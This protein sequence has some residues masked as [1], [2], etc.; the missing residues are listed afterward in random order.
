MNK[1]LPFLL[2][3]DESGK[4]YSHPYLKAAVQSGAEFKVCGLDEYINAPLGTNF[5]YLPNIY[6]VGYDPL[7]G[8]FETLEHYKGKKVFAVSSFFPPAYLR[9]NNTAGVYNAGSCI[10][11][12]WA[13]TA[14]GYY[15][16]NFKISAMRIDKRRRQSPNFYDDDKVRSGVSLFYERNSR[17]RLYEHLANC[18]LNY[19]C[20]AAKNMFLNRWE[21]PVPTA[22]RCNARCIGCI[23]KN[24]K[25][26][27][28]APHGRIS[29]RPTVCE[30]AELMEH[31]LAT[32][33]QAIVSFGQGCEGE[34]LLET[35]NIAAAISTVRKGVLRGTINMNTNGSLPEKVS[36]LCD[37]GMDSFRISLN[38]TRENI[39]KLYFRPYSYKFKDVIRSI[40]TAKHKNKFVSINLFVF[41]GVIDSEAEVKS[42][43]KFI[44]NTGIDMIQWRNLNIDT[45]LYIDLVKEKTPGVGIKT[46]VK[47]IKGKFP[48]LKNGYFNL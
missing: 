47:L 46:L 11:P 19:N 4:I 23:S 35:K 34:P 39:Y 10:L 14:C 25:D 37:A 9:L 22:Q 12:F 21:A 36:Q 16:G 3:S 44:D 5:F 28:C 42:L 45:K 8:C 13:Y 24:Q 38:S 27:P 30:I 1:H 41:P 31:H 33:P 20:L 6:P 29:F 48:K 32:A 2:F 15:G 40:N 7:S 26:F 17:N 18:A 43:L